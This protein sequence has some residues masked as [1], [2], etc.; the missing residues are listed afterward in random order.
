M[1]LLDFDA[2]KSDALEFVK[3]NIKE[4]KDDI[5]TYLDG[6]KDFINELALQGLPADRLQ[7][8]LQSTQNS[9]SSILESHILAA[10]IEA[11]NKAKKLALNLA[12]GI[13]KLI[14]AA[15]V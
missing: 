13:V 10:K 3:N 8:M 2:L 14:I 11:G 9:I 15:I 4:A 6:N 7:T 5:E 12:I 1:G